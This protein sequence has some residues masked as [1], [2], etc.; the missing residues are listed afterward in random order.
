[1]LT[2]FL[3][4]FALCVL[5]AGV[6]GAQTKKAESQ[7]LSATLE[8]TEGVIRL[9]LFYDK[10]PVTVSNF[11]DLARKGFY[12]G[13]IF[14][15][16]IPGFMIQ[17]GDPEGTGRGGP[18]YTFKDE[19]HADLKHDHK[20]MVSMANAGKDTNGSQ[21]FI[22][23]APT[24][25]LDNR[26]SIFGE[27]IEGYNV[28]EK[29]SKAETEGTKPKKDIKIKKITINGDWF[30]PVAVEKVKE[31]SQEEVT[32][33]SDTP[34]KK[35]LESIGQAIGLGKLISMKSEEA[36]VRYGA[37]NINYLA[38]FEKAKATKLLVTGKIKEDGS[39]EIDRLM[40]IK[41]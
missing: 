33:A 9:K 5:S 7:T 1:M 28:V 13:V 30:K 16:V 37:A 27:V 2:R 6:V 19:F 14:H 8:T 12:N 11:V 32:K 41:E 24:P 18:G 15:R 26:H 29:I 10:V 31:L 34:T 25:H 20:G 22:T 40:F 36:G 3:K 39:F 35:V 23:V 4:M 21:F 17:T 38:E